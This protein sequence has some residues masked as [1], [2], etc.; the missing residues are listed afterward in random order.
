M[1]F[2]T[3][4]KTELLE[5]IPSARHCR[6]AE[7]GGIVRSLGKISGEDNHLEIFSDNNLVIKK[8]EKLLKKIFPVDNIAKIIYDIKRSGKESGKIVFTPDQTEEL[9]TILKMNA[10]LVV[11]PLLY[12]MT[13]CKRAYLRGVFLSLGTLTD[14]NK[15]YHFELSCPD[16]ILARELQEIISE[17]D[18]ESK[19][20]RRRYKFVVYIKD[21]EKISELLSLL[22]AQVAMMELENVKILKEVRNQVN[23]Q[24]N[25]DSANINKALTASR[26]QLEDI[27]FLREKTGLEGLS[28]ELI[29]T[30]LLREKYPEATLSELVMYNGETVGKSGINHRLKKLSDIAEKLRRGEKDDY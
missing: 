4:V 2:T 23:R 5:D 21:S 12:T 7:L 30:A 22:G 28:E 18:V 6:I 16:E 27:S 29:E 26:K 9:L 14:P 17:F 10:K 15:D 3:K 25:C 20:V 11:K 1:N 8:A 19:V 24:V 13:C